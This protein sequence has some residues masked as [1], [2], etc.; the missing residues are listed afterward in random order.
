MSDAFISYSR[1]DSAF[2][3]RL[4]DTLVA[5]GK[6]VW[7]DWED[8]RPSADWMATI[9]QAIEDADAF[10][11]VISPTS[12]G[13]DVCARELAHAV[14]HHKRIVPIVV[15]EVDVR[16][17]PGAAARHQWIRA[18]PDVDFETV[19]EELLQT[20]QIDPVW[21]R[22]HTEWLGRALKW[23]QGDRDR[24]LLLNGRETTAAE[25][26][27]TEYE[28][29]AEPAPTELQRELI[30]ESRRAASRRQRIVF[31]A[32]ATALVVSLAATV[33]AVVQRNQAN[34][35][36]EQ[37]QVQALLGSARAELALDPSLGARLAVEAY[38]RRA[39][40]I[41]EA[42]L[43]KSMV[44]VGQ[45]TT[46]KGHGATVNDAAFSP[47]GKR[48]VTASDDGTAEV[49]DAA[50][51]DQLQMLKGHG[52]AVSRAAFSPDGKRIVTASEDKTA[53]LWDAETGKPIGEPLTGHDGPVLS[54]AFS[55]DGKRIVTASL[56]KTARLWDAE[57]GK[58]IGEPLTGHEDDVNSAA[59]SPDGKR[60][61]TASDDKTARLW[62]ADT[63]KPIGAAAHRP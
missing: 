61:V 43:R 8:I 3:R 42:L 36:K 38:A 55:P 10:V 51:G 58:P 9:Y 21:V 59:F 40:P 53:R 44:A 13:S 63:G 31:V 28:Q 7:I 47:D 48:I 12:V 20:L 46:L 6:E 54:A 41:T 49:W 37:A 57:T 18:T 22:R 56:D 16:N 27:L 33:V 30:R 19:V 25:S 50:S 5:R 26:W 60:I 29:G 2:A 39:T 52:G 4:H 11:F 32:T 17:L 45:R 35:Q 24:G 34:D 62:D 14:T 15:D 1:S 23:E